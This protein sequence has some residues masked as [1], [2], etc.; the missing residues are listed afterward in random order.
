M[1]VYVDAAELRNGIVATATVAVFRK[2]LREF[3]V[4]S[5]SFLVGV[6]SDTLDDR[7]R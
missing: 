6:K 1:S 2:F 5:L 7:I 4:S 3:D